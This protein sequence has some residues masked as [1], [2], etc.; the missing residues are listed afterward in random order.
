MNL[1]L[2]R[3]ATLVPQDHEA[4]Q[5]TWGLKGQK[6]QKGHNFYRSLK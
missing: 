5:A 3:Q 1:P 2:A 6:V 4:H